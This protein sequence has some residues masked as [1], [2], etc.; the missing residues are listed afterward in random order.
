MAGRNFTDYRIRTLLA[1]DGSRPYR[2]PTRPAEPDHTDLP[3]PPTLLFPVCDSWDPERRGD[4]CDRYPAGATVVLI[5]QCCL[6]L[7][8]E[9]VNPV[10]SK[11]L[12]VPL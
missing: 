4:T 2:R 9:K 5:T 7:G 3:R 8:R 1:A 12:R 11:R 10:C 6:P